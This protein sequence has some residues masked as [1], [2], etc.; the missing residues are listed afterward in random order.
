MGQTDEREPCLRATGQRFGLAKRSLGPGKITEPPAQLS[1]LDVAGRRVNGAHVLELG[2]RA[3]HLLFRPRPVT[4]CLQCPRVVHP[5]HA[6]EE[7][8]VRM[9][10]GPTRGRLG[11]LSG[12]PVVTHLLAGADQAAVHLA[13]GIGPEPAFH[14]EEHGLV[15]LFESLARLATV[16]QD[17][18]ERL[19]GLGLEVRVAQTPTEL[20]GDLHM[21][22]RLQEL[23]S[24][25]QHLDLAHDEVA[26]LRGL[27]VDLEPLP[28]SAEPRAGDA[29]LS[30]ERVVLVEPHR[31]LPCASIVPCRLV[32]RESGLARSD[33]VVHAA[34]PPRSVGPHIE[35]RAVDLG[36]VVRGVIGLGPVIGST[37]VVASQGGPGLLQAHTRHR[38][39]VARI[40]HR[41]LSPG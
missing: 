2:A 26:V 11:P 23:A 19:L 32:D 8:R 9:T 24:T 18:T 39:G 10:F 33:A 37:P 36:V 3:H 29:R 7:H 1:E 21:G 14:R 16:D 34:Q 12:A 22:G 35:P 40:A 15:E 6:W 5:A 27:G 17:A 13:G 25:V 4:T 30:S 38:T 41:H 28:C 20:E 31:R